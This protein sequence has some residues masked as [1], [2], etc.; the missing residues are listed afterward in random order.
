MTKD[1]VLLCDLTNV[2]LKT[3]VV[4]LTIIVWLY[5]PIMIS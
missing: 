4:T 5:D 2:Y 1:T 3:D